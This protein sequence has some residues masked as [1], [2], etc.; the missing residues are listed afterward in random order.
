VPLLCLVLLLL[1][2]LPLVL[3]SCVHVFREP[4]IAPTDAPPDGAEPVWVDAPV[5]A[6]LADG[7][8]VLFREGVT[9]TH[10]RVSGYGIAYSLGLADTSAVASLAMDDVLGL[11]AYHTDVNAPLSLL[12]SVG[13]TVLVPAAIVGIAC[14]MDPKCFG[15]CP[16]VYST[17]GADT[18]L[19]AELFSYSIAPLLEGRDV[20][21]LAGGPLDGVF[22]LDV[23]NEA[24][25]THFIN[26]VALLDVP[27]RADERVLPDAAEAPVAF[28][29]VR[30]P[31]S[32]RNADGADVLAPI[33]RRDDAVYST[34]PARTAAAAAGGELDDW[35]DLAFALPAE[36]GDSAALVL[37]MRNS[38][39]TSVL[40]YEMM[41]GAAGPAALT[42]MGD[43]LRQIGSA[44]QL[45]SWWVGRMGLRVEVLDAG[46]W[47]LVARV[48]D[49][50][51]IAWNEVAVPLPT[52]R[53]RADTLR[54]RVRFA[55]DQWRIDQVA[56]GTHARHAPFRTLRPARVQLSDGSPSDA[57][58]RAVRD[59]DDDYLETVAGTRFWIEFDT[60]PE[61]ADGERSL[62]LASQGFYNEWVRP[63]WLRRSP[64]GRPF[65]ADDATLREA[66]N[67]WH[68][69]REEFERR[70]AETRIPVR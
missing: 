61:P 33:A 4:R 64:A 69:T 66:M 10:D 65:T 51:P 20:D 13:A 15:S 36:P 45:G 16:T 63:V 23:R 27:R 1:L 18:V 47:R 43:E 35:I 54:I 26:Q 56:L 68:G 38:L 55:A 67:L 17:I 31:V 32:A 49:S 40:F 37:R 5:R 22:R 21:V 60:G 50:G 52:D 2:L 58:L 14:A 29:D 11:E 62:L 70:F 53:A 12:A 19:E 25:E 42:W 8:I 6:H 3:A 28:R 44:V 24:M 9:I 59:A 30:V 7:S 57:G 46:E 48:P 41:L 39:L 34:D